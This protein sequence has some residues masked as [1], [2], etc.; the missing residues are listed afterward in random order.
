[1]HLF[2]FY[3][4]IPFIVSQSALPSTIPI[5]N[6]ESVAQI[7]SARDTNRIDFTP[8]LDFL[9]LP[10]N[11]TLGAC[12]AVDID[13]KG[14]LYLFHRGKKPILCFNSDGKFLH[15][16]GD[17][18]IGKA[19]GLRIDRDDNIWVTDIRHHT[20]FKFNPKGKLLLALGQVDKP[21]KG[22]NQFNKPTDI[23][24]GSKGEIYISDGYGNSRVMKFAPNGKYLTHWGKPGKGPGEFDLPHSILVDKKDRVIVG[25]R[26]NNRVQIFD[27]HGKLLKIWPGF[28]PYGM[29]FDNR[30][31]LFV[32][33]GRANAV[34]QIGPAGKLINKWGK[35]GQR[36][37]EFYLPHML[38]S[39][40]SGNLYI[41]EVGNRRL[42]KLVR[43]R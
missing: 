10:K 11:I 35:K 13:S 2:S 5:D 37:G 4:A 1:M 33:D 32:A 43:K 24:F 9:K 25:D 29:A 6:P 16:W 23:A 15:G 8:S 28:A 3:A 40:K 27:A 19:H 41:T 30:G 31:T 7:Q 34:L 18:I 26:E 20:V 12:S 39:D 36:S 38:T 22:T 14:R 17:D 42:Q 21:G